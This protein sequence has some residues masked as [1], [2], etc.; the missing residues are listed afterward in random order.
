M[1][2]LWDLNTLSP[3]FVVLFIH[4][5]EA[6]KYCSNNVTFCTHILHRVNNNLSPVVPNTPQY[7]GRNY[8]DNDLPTRRPP[9]SRQ[10]CSWMLHSVDIS[11]NCKA[12]WS[13]TFLISG[14]SRSRFNKNIYY[15]PSFVD[16]PLISP[17]FYCNTYN[18]ILH[19]KKYNNR[20]YLMLK[21]MNRR[22]LPP[23]TCQWCT[24]QT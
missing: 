17:G 23:T 12:T 21:K 18:H 3:L 19:H 13:F 16:I 22:T 10:L 15:Q 1:Y 24:C 7:T 2:E 8:G 6:G 4:N 11:C 20:L 14:L 9:F 5:H